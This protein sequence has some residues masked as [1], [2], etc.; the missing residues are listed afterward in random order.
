MTEETVWRRIDHCE[1]KPDRFTL[2]T[3]NKPCK[4]LPASRDATACMDFC[5]GIADCTGINIVPLTLP[6]EVLFPSDSRNIPVGPKICRQSRLKN[7]VTAPN[8]EADALVCYPI[9]AGEQPDVG[10]VY[11][12]SD[13]PA[14]VTFYSTC[15]IRETVTKLEGDS[16]G[17]APEVKAAPPAY[18]F[19]NRCISC[20]LAKE[21][22]GLQQHI[23]PLW[24]LEQDCTKGDFE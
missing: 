14:D 11:T 7:L 1:Y 21:N 24:R 10:T 4:V 12:L 23:V 22:A 19:G 6:A 9:I 3:Q 20:A 16:S 15:L 5:A 13:D 8:T 2:A 18:I 17:E